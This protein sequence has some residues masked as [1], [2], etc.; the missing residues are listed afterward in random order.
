MRYDI[1]SLIKK[2]KNQD[3]GYIVVE[4]N[5]EAER[6]DAIRNVP[7]HV[8]DVNSSEYEFRKY[9]D[10]ISGFMFFL[11]TGIKPHGLPDSDFQLF[12]PII[13]NLVD[14]KCF[15]SAMLDSFI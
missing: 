10:F 15:T 9:R 6:M 14:K 11:N 2:Y 12:K 7:K 1:G 8:N 3:L 13:T 5:K 4:L